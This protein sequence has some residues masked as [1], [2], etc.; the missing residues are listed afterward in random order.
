MVALLMPQPGAAAYRLDISA[1]YRD[2]RLV[3]TWISLS[4]HQ[5]TWLSQTD[6]QTELLCTAPRAYKATAWV[7]AFMVDLYGNRA[8]VS[9]RPICA[10]RVEYRCRLRRMLWLIKITVGY[11]LTL[12]VDKRELAYIGHL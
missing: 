7:D 5:N 9:V 12:V 1:Q 10:I 11:K 3:V 4:R 8:R 6:G 2:D